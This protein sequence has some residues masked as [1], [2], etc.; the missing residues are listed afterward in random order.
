[1]M[2][3]TKY[4]TSEVWWESTGSGPAI[5]LI[6]GLSSPSSVWF[7][8]VPLLAPTHRVITFDNLGTGRTSTPSEPWTIRDMAEAGFAVLQAAGVTS[9]AVLGISLGGMIAEELTLNH[10]DIVTHLVL[11]STHAGLHH[12]EG[13][14]VVMAALNGGTDMEPDKRTELLL[15][16]TYAE[17]TPKE[18]WFEDAAVR[19][20]QPT[21]PEG[22]A[23]QLAAATPWDR[24]DDLR[25]ITTPTLILHGDEDRMVPM[26]GP[27]TLLNTIPGS[28]MTVLTG[29][30][31]QLFSDKPDEGSTIVLDFIAS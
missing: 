16:F 5:I 27:Q 22:Y 10:P 1:M 15:S 24:I 7:R 25:T 26:N 8:L 11:V 21:S 29:A 3:T 30:G 19:S 23:G 12:V 28:T 6:N 18:I 9:T 20:Q 31:H 14:P 2:P 13:D 4:G 17:A